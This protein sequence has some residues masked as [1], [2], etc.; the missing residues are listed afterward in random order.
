MTHQDKPAASTPTAEKA[1]QFVEEQNGSENTEKPAAGGASGIAS[2][3]QPRGVRP[4]GGPGTGMGSIGTG[5]G[6][7]GPGTATG[8]DPSRK[9]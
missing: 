2:G 4:G 6:S 3:L 8:T 7:T 5:G 1:K 9:A